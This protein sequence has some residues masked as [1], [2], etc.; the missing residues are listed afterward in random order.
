[1]G[2]DLRNERLVNGGEGL[3]SRSHRSQRLASSSGGVA[4]RRSVSGQNRSKSSARYTRGFWPIEV[5]AWRI[6]VRDWRIEVRCWP[7]E[8]R[9]L[10][11]RSGTLEMNMLLVGSAMLRVTC[12]ST[13]VA[14]LIVVNAMPVS[15]AHACLIVFVA[16]AQQ[17][18]APNNM[19]KDIADFAHTPGEATLEDSDR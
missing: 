6:E 8:V 18:C 5:R 11:S 4:S 15:Q 12:Q 19:E 1:M 2:L 13:I 10:A 17:Y 14:T 3:A 9:D 7:T 16:C